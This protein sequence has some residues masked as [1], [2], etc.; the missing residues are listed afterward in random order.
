[1]KHLLILA[2]TVL[3]AA[4]SSSGPSSSDIRNTFQQELPGILELKDFTLEQSRNTGSDESPVW[5][6][7][8]IAKVAPREATYD[9][10]TVEDGVRILKQVRAAG[11]TFTTYGTVRSTPREKGWQHRFQNDGSSDP[12]L[13]RPRS[14]Y[15]PDALVAGSPEA[16]TLLAEIK[17]KRE[18]ARIDEETRIAAEVAEQKR[19]EEAE[20]AKRKRV[21]A[22]VAKHSAAFATPTL[23]EMVKPGASVNFLVTANISGRQGVFGTDLYTCDSNFSK[24]VIH[25][26]LL[27]PDET[28]VVSVTRNAEAKRRD[29][30]G[31]PR[32]GINSA[33]YSDNMFQESNGC[34]VRLLERIP[35]E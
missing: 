30:I 1:M 15:G 2:L 27:K 24:T 21:E 3:L 19:K 16:D 4:C 29:F 8:V 7:R 9:I 5:V 12:I 10:D 25:A 32:N 28:G 22:A 34:T 31:S 26:G 13:G 35:S 20:A 14:D 17:R 33:N 6:A 11:E 18:Q 23:G